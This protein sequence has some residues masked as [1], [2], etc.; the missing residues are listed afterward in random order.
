MYNNISRY[1][2][3]WM[4]KKIK[5]IYNLER[6]EYIILIDAFTSL[7]HH[8]PSPQYQYQISHHSAPHHHLRI[9]I[10]AT[11]AYQVGY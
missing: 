7:A 1:I 3:K 11:R 9:D 4:N 6:M 5:A 10:Y 2:G 8:Y